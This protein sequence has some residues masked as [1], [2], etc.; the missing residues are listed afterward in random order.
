M[1]AHTHAYIH[2][3]TYT[4]TH[5][6]THTQPI[7]HPKCHARPPVRSDTFTRVY[8]ILEIFEKLHTYSCIQTHIRTY[9]SLHAQMYSNHSLC[10]LL[11]VFFFLLIQITPLF[12]F[13]FPSPFNSH[14]SFTLHLVHGLNI[15]SSFPSTHRPTSFYI[16]PTTLLPLASTFPLSHH[17]QPNHRYPPTHLPTDPN[18]ACQGKNTP[19]KEKNTM[20]LVPLPSSS[21]HI[22]MNLYDG[23][24]NHN[25]QEVIKFNSVPALLS[26]RCVRRLTTW[27]PQRQGQDRDV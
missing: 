9:T 26:K 11:C 22:I 27:C 23:K 12:P 18:W 3:H 17:S 6:H 10:S 21:R 16:L 15:T 13:L 8:K 1:R 25:K 24:K 7:T 14:D 2:T 4:H 19:C 5:T 20:T